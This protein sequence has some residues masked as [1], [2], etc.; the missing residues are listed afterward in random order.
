MIKK[1]ARWITRDER[2]AIWHH[3]RRLQRIEL[4]LRSEIE[5]GG[6]TPEY[7]LDDTGYVSERVYEEFREWL[8][9]R[10]KTLIAFPAVYEWGE[11]NQY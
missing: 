4:G 6:V 11:D 8:A 3:C 2:A 7:T 5:G 10:P 9:S 1:I